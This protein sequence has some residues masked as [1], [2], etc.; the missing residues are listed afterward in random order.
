M[1]VID[2]L[3]D[4]TPDGRLVL[5]LSADAKTLPTTLTLENNDHIYIPP[6]PTTVGV[7]G[8][9]YRP[10]SFLYGS[11]DRLGGYIKLAGGAEKYADK[12]DIF[13]VRANGSVLSRQV[14]KDFDRLAAVPGDVIFIP[15]RTSKTALQKLVEAASVI[16]Q[17]GVSAASI[18]YLTS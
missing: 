6:R 3:R 10:G 12:G 17:F 2:K 11:A 13:V 18:R 4:R 8:A 5:N 1:S 15:V 16:F 9:A 14:R 7:F